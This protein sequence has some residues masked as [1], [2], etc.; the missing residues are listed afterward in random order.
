MS[1]N[2]TVILFGVNHNTS[3]TRNQVIESLSEDGVDVRSGKKVSI[4]YGVI[5]ESSTEFFAG[6]NEYMSWVDWCGTWKRLEIVGEHVYLGQDDPP[7]SSN[8]DAGIEF[9]GHW[10]HKIINWILAGI[11]TVIA[12]LSANRARNDVKQQ[13]E[14]D[15]ELPAKLFDKSQQD[16]PTINR[17]LENAVASKSFKKQS[18]NTIRRAQYVKIEG[19]DAVALVVE[20]GPGDPTPIRKKVQHWFDKTLTFFTLPAYGIL[21]DVYVYSIFI[22]GACGITVLLGSTALSMVMW[23]AL[24]LILGPADMFGKQLYNWIHGRF[25]P[26]KY[27]P[28]RWLH[29][30]CFKPIQTDSA[31]LNF[32]GEVFTSLVRAPLGFAFSLLGLFCYY[33]I[34]K[35]Y[36]L[37]N[38]KD[39]HKYRLLEQGV[40]EEEELNNQKAAVIKDL[41][42][43]VKEQMQLAKAL[44]KIDGSVSDLYVG[45][46][47]ENLDRQLH[48]ST[49]ALKVSKWVTV[50]IPLLSAFFSAMTAF[51]IAQMGFIYW[52]FFYQGITVGWLADLSTGLMGALGIVSFVI[53]AIRGLFVLADTAKKTKEYAELHSKNEEAIK[54]I[55]AKVDPMN[56]ERVKRILLP[57]TSDPE[58]DLYKKA[59]AVRTISGPSQSVAYVFRSIVLP[60]TAYL[61]FGAI[62]VAGV[63]GGPAFIGI[64]VAIVLFS[65]I[66]RYLQYKKEQQLHAAQQVANRII[67]CN[68]YL[69]GPSKPRLSTSHGL[70]N[71]SLTSSNEDGLRGRK[72]SIPDEKATQLVVIK[73]SDHQRP[74]TP[75]VGSRRP[76]LGPTLRKAD[77]TPADIGEI[78]PDHEAIATYKT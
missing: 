62:T 13:K 67:A 32:L 44:E 26:S 52:Q 57:Q 73:I 53:A 29:R 37:L 75:P 9:G 40:Y 38:K 60:N 7:P 49:K 70:V 47:R 25:P 50:G 48:S 65:I 15:A 4:G 5:S 55:L 68:E 21:W 39:K 36:R 22:L 58:P 43:H 46:V 31:A 69:A 19:S 23:V 14:E 35:P 59:L 16:L 63:G 18:K 24:P 77:S 33:A 34:Y 17:Y 30:V 45:E 20:E 12:I 1:S 11:I 2:Y 74:F 56:L 78:S 42:A 66:A 6:N 61:C 76:S 71:A 54:Y 28:V 3:L 72:R 64:L 51:V 10:L 41:L 27:R 8:P